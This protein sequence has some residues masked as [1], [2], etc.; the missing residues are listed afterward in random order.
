MGCG[1]WGRGWGWLEQC[2]KEANMKIIKF[3][4]PNRQ[5]YLN[6]YILV[7]GKGWRGDDKADKGK[8]A[9]KNIIRHINKK[10]T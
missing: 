5:Q 6:K 10:G 8:N 4:F 9:V 1:V 7:R 2:Y 3:I